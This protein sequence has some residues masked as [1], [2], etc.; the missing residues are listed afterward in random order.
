M[1][2]AQISDTHV[3][4]PDSRN[5]RLFRTAEHLAAAVAHLNALHPRPDLVLAT[6]DLVERGGIDEYERLREILTPLAMPLF[7]IP[8]NHDD[9]ENLT[10]VFADHAYLPRNGAFLQYTVE[11]WPLRLVAL[12]TLVPG[13]SGGRLCAERLA[14]LEARLG[15]APD[16]PTL[17]FMH[18]PPFATGIAAMDDMGL[19]GIEG[20]AAVIRRHPQ[21]ERI[22]CGHLHRTI[23]RRFAGTVACTCPATAHQIA[24]DLVP[25]QRLATVMEP[26][27][28]MLHLWLGEAGGLVSHVS[29]IGD[30]HPPFTVFDGE[31]WF[32][33]AVPPAGFHRDP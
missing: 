5:D 20:L 26:P 12:D 29:L 9:R 18:H 17:V 22:T 10:K 2:I 27:A 31:R 21:V 14:W 19:D 1:L 33:D 28:C 6:G 4:T 13:K 30:R 24:L 8:G 15:E 3:S 7:L 32:R 25:A 16:R 11:D 23:V